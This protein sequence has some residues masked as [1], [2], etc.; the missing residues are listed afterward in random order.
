MTAAEAELTLTFT[1]WPSVCIFHILPTFYDLELQ[2]I[3]G[4][5]STNNRIIKCDMDLW[6]IPPSSCHPMSGECTCRPGWSGLYCNKTCAPGFYGESCREVC[7]CQNGADCHSV[8]GACTCAPGFMVNTSR[9]CVGLMGCRTCSSRDQATSASL[10][11]S[12]WRQMTFA[13]ALLDFTC[14]KVE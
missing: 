3:F 8:T 1:N 12:K 14:Q 6:F 11:T 4:T 5:C 2:K 10:L 7:K 9:P 13:S